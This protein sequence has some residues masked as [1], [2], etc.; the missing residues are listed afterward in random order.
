[1][2]NNVLHYYAPDTNKS[3]LA[4]VAQA[5]E[6]DA[7]L[8]LADFWTDRTHTQPVPAALMAGEFAAHLAEGDV[9]SIEEVTGWLD[10]TGW[11][12]DRHQPL[13]GPQSALIARR[14]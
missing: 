6:P 7:L 3:V 4:R 11:Q 2:L 1:M 5:V 10:E 14:V 8:V 13:A 9:Y 12:V